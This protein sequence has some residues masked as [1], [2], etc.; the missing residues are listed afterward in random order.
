M[1]GRLQIATDI[2]GISLTGPRMTYSYLY[3][4]ARVRDRRRKRQVAGSNGAAGLHTAEQCTQR[5]KA[6]SSIVQNRVASSYRPQSMYQLVVL[7]FRKDNLYDLDRMGDVRQHHVGRVCQAYPSTQ[8]EGIR[9]KTTSH[10]V[11]Y[12]VPLICK[13]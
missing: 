6:W 9:S 12:L 13:C 5:N 11:I 3:I 8:R 10:S 1:H 4:V 7:Y 2:V